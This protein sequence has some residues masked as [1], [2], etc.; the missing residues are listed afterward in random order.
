MKVWICYKEDAD[1][2]ST[3]QVVDRIWTDR[4]QA[5]RAMKAELLLRQEYRDKS[6]DDLHELCYAYLDEIETVPESNDE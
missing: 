6:P 2:L 4:Y 5:F 1:N 3:D